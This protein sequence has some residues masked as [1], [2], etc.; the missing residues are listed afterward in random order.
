[1]TFSPK[2]VTIAPLDSGGLLEVARTR[3]AEN[4]QTG[5]SGMDKQKILGIAVLLVGAIGVAHAEI[6]TATGTLVGCYKSNQGGLRLVDDAGQ[7]NP[8][9]K[10]VTWNVVGPMGPQGPAGLQGVQ[11]PVGP[12]GPAGRT[13]EQGPVGDPGPQ[14]VPGQQGPEGPAGPQGPAGNTANV[15]FNTSSNQ[16]FADQLKDCCSNFLGI[17]CGD[18]FADVSASCPDGQAVVNCLVSGA[19]DGPRIEGNGCVATFAKDCTLS[20]SKTITA[21]CGYVH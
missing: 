20:F 5:V 7:C 19:S 8:S 6:P 1:M 16:V 4:F 15:S 17:G 11:G 12:Q 2:E 14:G 9:E 10:S 3:S 21:V 18:E 13:G